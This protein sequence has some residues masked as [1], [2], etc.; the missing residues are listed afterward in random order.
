MSMNNSFFIL[1]LLISQIYAQTIIVNCNT[2]QECSAL[3]GDGACCLYEEVLALNRT[4]YNCRNKDFV[5]YYLNP[6]NYDILQ[7]VWTNPEDSTDRTTVYCKPL[8]TSYLDFT[9]PC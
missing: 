6:K 8:N 3:L 7:Q 5:N 9:Y 2:N 1:V 4:Q